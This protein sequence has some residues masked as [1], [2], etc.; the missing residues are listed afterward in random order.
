MNRSFNIGGV[1]SKIFVGFLHFSRAGF[2]LYW[3]GRRFLGQSF[4]SF[5]AGFRVD[6][7]HDSSSIS[8]TIPGPILGGVFASVFWPHFQSS[9]S[10][11]DRAG[12]CLFY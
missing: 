3:I 2:R 5:G 8:R 4:R 6:F 10:V 9:F 12:N 1:L 11:G 7:E